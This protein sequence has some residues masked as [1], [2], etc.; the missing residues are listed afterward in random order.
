M[1]VKSVD[2]KLFNKLNIF[3]YN[4]R[5]FGADKQDILK[6]LAVTDDKSI[7]IIC[8]QENFLLSNNSYK[9]KQC[10][11]GSDIYFKKAEMDLVAGRTKN[12]M[13]IA[14]PLAFK[15]Y[16]KNE[17]PN[18][19]RIQAVVIRC[20]NS[21]TLII[22][23]YFPTDPRTNDFDTSDLL[24]T[25]DAINET[26][27]TVDFDNVVWTGDINAD[28]GRNSKFTSLV[29][30]FVKDKGLLRARDKYSD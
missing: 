15:E 8:N 30:E 5:G 10:L 4:S 20:E 7:P 24:S 11:P 18:H 12:G 28:F 9:V 29:D 14:V 22:N 27:D 1:S 19:W 6:T 13:F 21:K 3:S 16:V 25:I 26:L 23:S 2:T 17:S